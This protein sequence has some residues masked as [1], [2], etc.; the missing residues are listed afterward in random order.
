[1][2]GGGGA[3][4]SSAESVDRRGLQRGKFLAE[5]FSRS[6]CFSRLS[7]PEHGVLRD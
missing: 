2:R 1:M 5:K 7:S 4:G 6:W 3:R